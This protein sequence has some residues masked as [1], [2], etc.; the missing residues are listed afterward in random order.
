ME[1]GAA[2]QKRRSGTAWRFGASWGETERTARSLIQGRLPPAVSQRREYFART[3]EAALAAARRELGPEALLV[4]AGPA[5]EDESRGAYRVVC[6]G[7]NGSAGRAP[8]GP[9]R[10]GKEAAAPAGDG[11]ASRLAKLERMLHMVAEAVAALDSDAGAAAVRAELAA[12]DFPAEWIGVLLGAAQ[13]RLEAEPPGAALD[14]ESALRTAVAEELIARIRFRP[15]LG[16]EGPAVVVFAGPPGS[17][18][19]TMLVK[20]AMREGLGRRRPAA[21]MSTDCHR[22]SAAEQLRTYAG[23]LGLP[24]CQAETQAALRRA[25]AEHSAR[26][27]ILI[28]TPGFSRNE[29]DWALEWAALLGGI[30]RRQTLLVLPASWRTRDL[31]AALS[32][33]AAFEPSSLAF[34]RIDETEAAGGWATAALESGLPVAYFGTGQSIPEDLEPA[35]GDRLRAALGAAPARRAEAS[36]AA[37]GAA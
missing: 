2:R 30:P 36:R 18:K 13:R 7:E 11:V 20:V 4:E 35:S 24:F 1:P 31:V 21:I 15:E 25:V 22:V 34:T 33:W 23:I 27:L 17:G 12:Q 6:E 28:D 14:G 19:T 9:G 32:W 26:S 37:G 3:L 16:Q 8:S 10:A 5:G 29:G